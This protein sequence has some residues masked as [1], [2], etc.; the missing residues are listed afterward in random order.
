MTEH[1]SLLPGQY[2]TIEFN[3]YL[4]YRN[5]KTDAFYDLLN[6]KKLIQQTFQQV[7]GHFKNTLSQTYS[8]I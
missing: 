4:I 1:Y 3:N 7:S 6:I 8:I 2:S 5:I